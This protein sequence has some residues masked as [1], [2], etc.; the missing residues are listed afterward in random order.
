VAV[1]ATIVVAWSSWASYDAADAR[2]TYSLARTFASLADAGSPTL[3]T[4]ERLAQRAHWL[5]YLSNFAL[6]LLALVV[7]WARAALRAWP[8]LPCACFVLGL[9]VLRLGSGTWV[10]AQAE[11]VVLGGLGCINAA[12]DLVSARLRRRATSLASWTLLGLGLAGVGAG[13]LPSGR[14]QWEWEPEGGAVRWG[15]RREK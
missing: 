3:A 9:V 6:V 13:W 5:R 12:F 15:V 4:V 7:Y 14:A 10:P 1:V 8:S 2:L 11:F